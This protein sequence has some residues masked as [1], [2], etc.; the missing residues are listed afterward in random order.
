MRHQHEILDHL[1]LWL[2]PWQ[3]R[4]AR[5]Y[6]KQG[7]RIDPV[8]SL[9]LAAVKLT[10]DSALK[11]EDENVSMDMATFLNKAMMK[12]TS[13]PQ[14]K[15]PSGIFHEQQQGKDDNNPSTMI[16]EDNT[17]SAMSTLTSTSISSE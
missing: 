13:A 16:T 10:I 9:T 12:I 2:H 8:Q 14:G 1:K 17:E 5:V 7:Q 4:W 15:P 3:R 6:S 11:S